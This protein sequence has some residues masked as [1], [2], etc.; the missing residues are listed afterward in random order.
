[1]RVVPLASRTT[2]LEN[3]ALANNKRR[4]SMVDFGPAPT[5]I[6]NQNA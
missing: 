5:S 6:G 1:M 3:D 4:A 2:S